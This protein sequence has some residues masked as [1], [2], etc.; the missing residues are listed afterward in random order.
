M[1]FVGFHIIMIYFPNQQYNNYI[2]TYFPT[3]H[4]LEIANTLLIVHVVGGL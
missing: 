2:I 4:N 1:T 3:Q